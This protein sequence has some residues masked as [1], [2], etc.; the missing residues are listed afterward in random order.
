MASPPECPD[1]VLSLRD[2][3][4][5]ATTAVAIGSLLNDCHLLPQAYSLPIYSITENPD[6]L[7]LFVSI[8]A[9]QINA[10][11]GDIPPLALITALSL[12]CV[13]ADRLDLCESHVT[14]WVRRW[15]QVSWHKL[16]AQILEIALICNDRQLIMESYRALVLARLPSSEVEHVDNLVDDIPDPCKCPDTP[17][18]A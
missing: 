10:D 8:A 2:G 15:I 4:M 17:R 9:D 16:K 1:I 18:S 7:Q 14:P 3:T 13:K 6:A 5:L 11:F 12:L